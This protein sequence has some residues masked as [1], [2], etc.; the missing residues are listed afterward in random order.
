MRRVIFSLLVVAVLICMALPAISYA[1]P[2][3]PPHLEVDK[4]TSPD[5]NGGKTTVTLTVT[6]AGQPAEERLPVDVMLILDRS[7]SMSTDGKLTAAKE[8]AKAFIDLLDSSKDRVGLV[9]Y[10]DSATLNQG[11]TGPVNAP[12]IVIK[13]LAGAGSCDDGAAINTANQ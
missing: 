8:A 9:S 6:G 1:Q 13:G 10:S 5:P 11:S 3:N 4:D 12:S 7:E 2:A